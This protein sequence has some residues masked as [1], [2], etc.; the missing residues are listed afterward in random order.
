MSKVIESKRRLG[1]LPG[2]IGSTLLARY[3]KE[4]LRPEPSAE[5][6]PLSGTLSGAQMQARQSLL[7]WCFAGAGTGHSRVLRPSA[8]PGVEER[9]SIAVLTGSDTIGKLQ[10][11][12]SLCRELDGS[13]LLEAC[14]GRLAKL[15]LRVAVKLRECLWWRRRQAGDPWDSGYLREEAL[16]RGRVAQFLPRRATLVIADKL[17]R[18]TLH[19][20]VETLRRRSGKFGHPVRLLITDA[21]LPEPLGLQREAARGWTAEMDGLGEV[22]AVKLSSETERS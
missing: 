19:K 17:P 15:R 4:T 2:Y 9:L 12:E 20:A 16:A 10:L 22:L 21:V 3:D 8:L 5:L 13:A 6:L 18:E 7:D 14:E 11:A 1:R